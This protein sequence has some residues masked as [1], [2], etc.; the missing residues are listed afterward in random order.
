MEPRVRQSEVLLQRCSGQAVVFRIRKM[1]RKCRSQS[2]GSGQRGTSRD[3]VEK[4]ER[5]SERVLPRCRG[6]APPMVRPMVIIT[7]YDSADAMRLEPAH[8]ATGLYAARIAGPDSSDI[9]MPCA[10]RAASG[11]CFVYVCFVCALCHGV[12]PVPTTPPGCQWRLVIKD[13]T[14][15]SSLSEGL[16]D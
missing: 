5:W 9:T 8:A 13:G 2:R 14:C 10:L 15:T 4:R 6:V 7:V 11:I 3:V 1:G 12:L 16:R